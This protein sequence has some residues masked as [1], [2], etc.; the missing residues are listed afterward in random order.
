ML[1]LPKSRALRR[2]AVLCPAVVLAA[3]VAAAAVAG[4]HLDLLRNLSIA[5]DAKAIAGVTSFLDDIKGY[6]VSICLGGVSVAG[7]AVAAAKFAGHSRAND[8]IFNI[9]VG[10]AILAA[11]PTLVA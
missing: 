1:S 2:A 11:V 4:G 10:I 3:L 8:M 9:G 7:V 6:L 5:Q